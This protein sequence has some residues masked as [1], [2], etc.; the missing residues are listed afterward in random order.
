MKP[1]K[2][3]QLLSE[4]GE[5]LRVYCAPEDARLRK[6]RKQKGGNS[7]AQ[8]AF[9]RLA[10]MLRVLFSSRADE[11][12][13]LEVLFCPHPLPHNHNPT[14]TPTPPTHPQARTSQKAGWSLRTSALP[15]G[16]RWR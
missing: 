9:I 12:P 14:T 4:H 15:S 11:Q 1:M 8:E 13:S 3:K 16:W 5:T 10:C 7:G 2:L 6:A